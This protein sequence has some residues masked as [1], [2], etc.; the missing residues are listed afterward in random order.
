MLASFFSWWFA[1]LTELL[2][3]AWTSAAT[4]LRDGIVINADQGDDVTASIRRQDGKIEPVTLGAAARLATRK[5]VMVRPPATAVLI[6][7]HT[8]PTAPRRQLDQL[9]RYE[10]ARITPF[11]SDALFWRWDAALR[12][13]DRGRA[14]VTLTM[15]PKAVLEHALTALGHVGIVPDFVETGPADHPALLPMHELRG[16]SG[17]VKG[18]LVASCVAAA[19]ALL[20]PFGLQALAL[21]TT[22]EGI[23]EL[24]PAIS[25]IDA[26]RRGIAAGD[27]GREILMR[28]RERTGDVLQT[29]AMLTRLLPD[30]TYLT[31][32]GMRE[33]HM[34]LSGR[35][36]SAPRLI[37]GLS[38]DPAIHSPT[39]AA[40]VTRTE[41]ATSDIFS[42][43]ADLAQ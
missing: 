3:N 26:L 17:L 22:E 5:P 9:L 19:V 36:A 4:R 25:R 21:N 10:L 38:A 43:K 27:A 8:V 24:Q 35:S 14:N 16:R 1:R 37:T 11:P 41:G 12:P 42:I 15:V 13:G 34:T 31:D 2:P 23:A 40:P 28:E 7:M 30:D 39:F 33:R 32:F 29:L 6:K 18:L 20:L